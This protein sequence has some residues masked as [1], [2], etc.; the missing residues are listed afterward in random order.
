ML[1]LLIVLFLASLEAL[2]VY[3]AAACAAGIVNN[4]FATS[5]SPDSTGWAVMGLYGVLIMFVLVR[6]L[7]GA[8]KDV[9]DS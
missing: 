6:F 9:L 7:E 5:L 2:A 1:K 8:V 4:H 3:T